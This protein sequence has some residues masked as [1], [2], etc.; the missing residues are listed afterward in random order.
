MVLPY[1]G[2]R[3]RRGT[4]T[5][6]VCVALSRVTTP[7]KIRLGIV[8]EFGSWFWFLFRRHGGPA[9]LALDRFDLRD[10]LPVPPQLARGIQPLGLRL[11]PQAEQVVFGFLEREPEL[12]VA[13]FS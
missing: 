1:T 3:T 12:L 11:H 5:R 10:Q 4:S 8:L 7:V 13:H 2:C 6:R 9:A